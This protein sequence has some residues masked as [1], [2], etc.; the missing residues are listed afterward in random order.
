MLSQ[1]R[2]SPRA[3][4]CARKQY[5]RQTTSFLRKEESVSK[6]YFHA[7]LRTTSLSMI[8]HEGSHSVPCRHWKHETLAFSIESEVKGIQKHG[9]RIWWKTASKIDWEQRIV[10]D[11]E[12]RVACALFDACL[13]LTYERF[14][15]TMTLCFLRTKIHSEWIYRLI[16]R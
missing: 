2:V 9:A 10:P 3:F 11:L 7:H 14:I 6:K 12:W 16:E 4:A 8:V 13:K 5:S 15:D 1:Q